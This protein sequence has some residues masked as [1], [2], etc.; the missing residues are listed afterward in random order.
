MLLAFKVGARLVLERSFT[1][2]HSVLHL[3]SSERVTGFPIVPTIV[4]ILL[5]LNLPRYDFS[6]VRYMTNTGAALPTAHVATLRE[7]LPG[8]RFFSMYG[9]TECKRVAYLPPEEL[10]ARPASVG[11]AIPNVEVYLVDDEG[12]RIDHGVGELVIRGSNVMRGYWE[13]PEETARVLRPGPVPGQVVLHSGD[14]FRMDEEGY[15]YFV[16]RKDDV[17]KTRGEKVSPREVENVIHDLSGVVE[18]A[19]VGEPDPVLGQLV[20]AFVVAEP[21]RTLSAHDVLRHCAHHLEDFM[22]PKHVRFLDALPKTGS[23]KV[24]RRLLAD[25][26]LVG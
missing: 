1:Y 21:T 19:V 16:S 4:A 24:D 17:I 10:D 7:F 12:R 18:A 20:V 14:V 9:L 11:K 26:P 22:I 8:V 2:P 23:G 5:R 3:I 13:L 15:L 25:W 6:S